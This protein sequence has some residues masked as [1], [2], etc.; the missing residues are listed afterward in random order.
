MRTARAVS[1]ALLA[2]AV[3]TAPGALR[4][5]PGHSPLERA[6]LV[7]LGQ[8]SS[9]VPAVAPP[10]SPAEVAMTPPPAELTGELAPSAPAPPRFTTAGEPVDGE[11]LALVV[12]INDYPGRQSDLGAA[13]ADADTID[14]ALAGFGVPA[15]NRMVLRDGQARRDGVVAA[16]RALADR[17]GA[18]STVVFAY[19]GHVRKVGPGRE[20]LV[21]ADGGLITDEELA[22]LLAPSAAERMWLLLA[23]CFAG[24]FTE[25]L[26]PGRILTGAAGADEI[27][28]ESPDLNASFLVHHLV[29]EGWLEGQAGPSVQAAFAYADARLA[30]TRPD[31]RPVQVD[32]LGA[33]L[34]LGS[35]DPSSLGSG[36]RPAASP[37]SAPSQGPPG[38]SPPPPQ[39][40]ATPPPEPR[41]EE[42]TCTLGVLLCRRR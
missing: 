11:V 20:A 25:A 21:T 26:A 23:T 14:A 7:E 12:G 41:D 17:A 34:V 1:V 39:Q 32:S 27:A 42:T 16:I 19:A 40:P 24:G 31:R 33:P 35:G 4:F 10:S 6:P 28:Y 36:D 29:R 13:V 37:A 15:G 30:A 3:V 8:M 9:G 5:L 18:G 2:L 22:V 38:S